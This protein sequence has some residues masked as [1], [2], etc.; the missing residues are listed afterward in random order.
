MGLGADSYLR[1]ESHAVTTKSHFLSAVLRNPMQVGAILPSS[2]GLTSIMADQIHH[3][4]GIT[5]ELGPGTGAVTSALLSRGI[6]PEQLLLIEKDHILAQ[7]LSCQFPEL[8]VLEGDAARL[9]QL[10]Q[11]LTLGPIDNVVSSLPL[12]NMR[13]HTRLR[14]LKQ[15][16]SL[17]QPE[18]KFIQ[19]TYSPRPPI[20]E[21]QSHS[22][23][24]NGVRT[25]RVLWNLP[26]A[27][28]WVYRKTTTGNGAMA[29]GNRHP[30][31]CIGSL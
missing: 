25:G 8:R 14:I 9:R 23:D 2:N 18:G 24:I 28:V 7:T 30:R 16:S 21:R 5:I 22:L 31:E 17:L 12:L 19:F 11:R 6:N 10:L 27:H 13:R 15:I 3:G 4:S 29:L 26:P 20:T 1:K